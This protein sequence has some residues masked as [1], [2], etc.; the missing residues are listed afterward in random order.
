M[1]R[2]PTDIILWNCHIYSCLSSI[3]GGQECTKHYATGM[4]N[5]TIADNEPVADIVQCQFGQR[6]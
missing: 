2:Q 4:Y 1:I 5:C 6:M 3:V